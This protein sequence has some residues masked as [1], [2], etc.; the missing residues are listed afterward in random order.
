[1]T[2][3]TYSENIRKILQN[4]K[5]IEDAFKIKI[6][7]EGRILVLEGKPEDE[8]FSLRAITAIDLG[9]SINDAVLLK[10]ENFDFEKIS[11]KDLSKR[12][13]LAQVRARIIGSRRKALN[14][15]ESLTDCII[16]VHENTVGIIGEIENIGKAIY[17]IKR[18]ISGSNHASVYAYLEEQKALERMKF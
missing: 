5:L 1:M 17:A 10:D 18:I 13:N 7:Y 12:K 11:V 9:F 6:S 15:I 3:K 14:T 16:S 2:T 4:R 8:I